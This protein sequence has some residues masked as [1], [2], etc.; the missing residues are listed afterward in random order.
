[1]ASDK[2]YATEQRLSDHI[3]GGYDPVAGWPA[4]EDW[5]TLGTP[6]ATGYSSVRGRYKMLATGEVE[7]DIQLTATGGAVTAGSYTYANTLPTAY[8][9]SID[10]QLALGNSG[11]GGQGCSLAVL[12]SGSVLVVVDATTPGH[13]RVG[14]SPRMPLD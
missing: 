11:T 4:I 14:G 7:F 2:S 6:S 12:T 13:A 10:R 1:M 9:P 8:R 5:H 3:A